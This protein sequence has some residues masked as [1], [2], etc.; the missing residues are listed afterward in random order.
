QA[1]R[2]GR[3]RE[4]SP[5]CEACHI[6]EVV[7]ALPGRAHPAHVRNADPNDADV[8]E[9]RAEEHVGGVRR[10]DRIAY[11]S[12]NHRELGHPEDDVA[13]RDPLVEVVEETAEERHEN[14]LDTVSVSVV[15][16]A[17]VWLT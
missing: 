17:G 4:K 15:C 8:P 16:D 9:L 1:Q 10:D 14:R 13:V 3:A 5:D 11:L 2:K 12:R 6:E 7:V